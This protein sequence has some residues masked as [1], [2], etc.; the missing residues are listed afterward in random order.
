MDS[1]RLPR[2]L[3]RREFVD[4]FAEDRSKQYEL[5]SYGGRRRRRLGF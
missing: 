2:Y 1:L 4:R 3:A 5:N